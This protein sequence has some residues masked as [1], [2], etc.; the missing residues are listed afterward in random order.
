MEEG[1]KLSH[2]LTAVSA[3]QKTIHAKT[4]LPTAPTVSSTL[5]SA[6]CEP[7]TP[8]SSINFDTDA[9]RTT[10]AIAAQSKRDKV[11]DA[12]ITDNDNLPTLPS[13]RP[14]TYILSS[15]SEDNA[16]AK[17]K[18]ASTSK[19]RSKAAPATPLSDSEESDT[20]P[21][22][23]KLQSKSW[24]WNLFFSPPARMAGASKPVAY[25]TCYQRPQR[26]KM[27][28]KRLLKQLSN[29]PAS[30]RTLKSERLKSE[31]FHTLMHYSN[32]W[33]LNGSLLLTSC[34]AHI[35]NLATQVLLRTYSHAKHF[36]PEDESL[37][38]MEV[39]G[40]IRDEVGLIQGITVKA[41]SSSKWKEHL[42]ALQIDAG[43]VP[44]VL[45]LDMKFLNEFIYQM[46]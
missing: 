45:L 14:H 8:H 33:L 11:V 19:S 2:D 18:H 13:Q 3:L 20:T 24:D 35:V 15:S 17:K 16:P 37:H 28:Q 12:E 22:I 27:K 42:Y 10:S 40:Y 6:S 44:H 9:A 36:S 34:L 31:L 21:A 41:H 1:A 25:N 26:S 7:P 32:K 29:S 4:A 46:G 30:S 39:T 23:A 43:V 38:D 5:S